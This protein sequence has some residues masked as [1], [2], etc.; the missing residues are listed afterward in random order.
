MKFYAAILNQI[1]EPL[2]IDE[3]ENEKL[4]E[5][6]VLLKII[7]TGI[8]RSQIFEIFGGRGEDKWLPHLLG[9]EAIGWVIDIGKGVKKVKIGEKV[10][11]TWIS[12]EG[13]SANPA[14]YV[15]R[16]KRLNGG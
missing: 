16:N 8:C 2:I 12:S 1:N 3:I 7:K 6:Q 15:W 4:L 13:I 5:G 10:I 9:H 11:V 14:K